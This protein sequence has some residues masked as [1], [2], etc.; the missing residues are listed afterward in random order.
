MATMRGIIAGSMGLAMLQAIVSSE[1]ATE[2]TNSLIGFVSRGIARWFNPYTALIPDLRS[3]QA[4]ADDGP[5]WW[6]AIL[7]GG[8]AIYNSSNTTPSTPS[9]TTPS[10]GVPV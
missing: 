6:A 4:I 2:N 8:I 1:K 9:A 7:P 10:P 3:A 5:P